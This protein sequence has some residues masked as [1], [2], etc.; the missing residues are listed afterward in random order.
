MDPDPDPPPDGPL[1]YRNPADDAPPAGRRAA[2][3]LSGVAA[4]VA[5]PAL[6]G[7]GLV[8]LF[9]GAR[10]GPTDGVAVFFALVAAAAIV[11]GVY[12]LRPAHRR[13]FLA[14]FL[15]ALGVT[16]AVEGTCF[17]S[18]VGRH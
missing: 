9:D 13:W 1:G 17:V 5:A 18:L 3:V 2:L 7:F 8:V 4:G 6:V 10:R 12:A 14:S 11:A 16:A 15:L